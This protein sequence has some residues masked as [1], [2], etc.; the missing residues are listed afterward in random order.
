MHG[1][2]QELCL[3]FNLLPKRQQQ[4]EEEIDKIENAKHRKLVNLCKTRWVARI[5]AYEVFAELLTAVVQALEVISTE[6]GWN[7]ESSRKASSLLTAVTQFSFLHAFTI[8]RNVLGFIK[9]LTTSLQSRT[10]DIVYAYSQVEIVIKTIDVG[11]QL[12]IHHKAWFDEV[13]TPGRMW[14]M[15]DCT[16]MASGDRRFSGNFFNLYFI[17]ITFERNFKVFKVFSD[18]SLVIRRLF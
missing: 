17:S 11:L 12:D 2:L 5:E 16:C 7:M 3:F 10:L 14:D 9:G 1:T 8:T 18:M 15:S 6:D 4:L 13:V